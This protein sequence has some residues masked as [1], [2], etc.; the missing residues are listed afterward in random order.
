MLRF[1]SC[2]QVGI[3]VGHSNKAIENAIQGFFGSLRWVGLVGRKNVGCVGPH[4]LVGPHWSGAAC[5]AYVG[6]ARVVVAKGMDGMDGVGWMDWR[7]SGPHGCGPCTENL[8]Y[9]Y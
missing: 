2:K 7:R 3:L 6:N 8:G 9:G 1:Q 4:W 5:V